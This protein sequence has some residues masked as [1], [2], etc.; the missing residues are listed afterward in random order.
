MYNE[1]DDLFKTPKVHKFIYLKTSPKLCYERMKKRNR[2]EEQQI[3]IEYFEA[4]H[5]LHEE[6]L[7]SHNNTLI[8][9]GEKQF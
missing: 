7:G 9:D 5:E 6:W 3:P 1:L 2:S 4:I 8:V